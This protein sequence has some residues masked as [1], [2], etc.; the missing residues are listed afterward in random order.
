[1]CNGTCLVLSVSLIGKKQG[2]NITTCTRCDHPKFSGNMLWCP[3]CN[4]RLRSH[5]RDRRAKLANSKLP[6]NKQKPWPYE[7][8]FALPREYW[9]DEKIMSKIVEIETKYFGRKPGNKT[10]IDGVMKVIKRYIKKVESL[11]EDDFPVENLT[12]IS[13]QLVDYWKGKARTEHNMRQHERRFGPKREEILRK[14][15][16][17]AA[18]H[19]AR[20]ETIRRN[21][22]KFKLKYKN[23]PEFRKE[24]LARHERWIQ[25]KKA[26]DPKWAEE[27]RR[28]I[29]RRSRKRYWEEKNKE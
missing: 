20:K 16:E 17:Y 1:M 21:Q 8:F 3:C 14:E 25:R 28:R 23:D 9:E 15:R 22:E 29:N 5:L 7:V 18:R 4:N 2:S 11:T 24:V 6:P 19:P 10:K 13:K 12:G 27:R 26:K